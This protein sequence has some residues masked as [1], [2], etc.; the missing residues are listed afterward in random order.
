MS[1]SMNSAI[2]A[3][4]EMFKNNDWSYDFNEEKTLFT[5]TFNLSK[6]KLGSVRIMIRVRPTAADA[7]AARL[8][9]GYGLISLKGDSD[10]MAQV[11]EYLTR[12]NYGLN[13]GNFELDHRD[14]EIRYKVAINCRDALPGMDALEDLCGITTAMYNKYGN[15][16]L[17]VCMGMM[18]AEDAIKKAEE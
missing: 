14:G 11:C 6:S 10:C 16:L 5:T 4:K 17:A 1:V 18:S 8:I 3:V 2:N 12:A 15:G 13:I 7:N 9:V